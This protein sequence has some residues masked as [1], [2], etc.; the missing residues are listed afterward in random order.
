MD[1]ILKHDH[2]DQSHYAVLSRE[3]PVSFSPP[4]RK[5]LQLEAVYHITYANSSRTFLFKVQGFVSL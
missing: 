3:A 2:S 5:R 4:E 1:E